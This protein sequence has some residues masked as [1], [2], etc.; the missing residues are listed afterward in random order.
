MAYYK[1]QTP[2]RKGEDYVYPL[3]T[4]DQ[5]I[6]ENGERLNAKY[7][8]VELDDTESGVVPKTNANQLGGIDAEAYATKAFVS[9]E[10]ANAQLGGGEGADIDLSGFMLKTDT[11]VDSEKLGGI[12]AENYALKSDLEDL[13]LDPVIATDENN[14]GNIVLENYVS[15]SYAEHIGDLGNPHNVTIAQIG[16]A[17]AG[18]G[19]GG[20]AVWLSDGTDIDSVVQ[21][22]WYSYGANNI[23]TN[24]PYTIGNIF[25]LARGTS[26]TC[27]QLATSR[28][29]AAVYMK[30]RVMYDNG[31]WS[32][33][34]EFSPS[35]FAPAG[36]GL[37]TNK[38]TYVT[39]L[40]EA[41]NAGWY[42]NSS[43]ALN[44]PEQINYGAM[45]VLPRNSTDFTQILT[46]VS[47]GI[48]AYR[49]STNNGFREWKYLNGRQAR[50]VTVNSSFVNSGSITA[51]TSGNILKIG[52]YL[53][54]KIQQAGDGYTTNIICTI[55]G[56]KVNGN[57]YATVVDHSTGKPYNILLFYNGTNTVVQLECASY[58]LP[59]YKWLNFGIV[60]IIE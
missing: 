1:L 17:P 57:T 58:A 34:E 47:S 42:C 60:G 25:V 27:T 35:A 38:G 9:A 33:W 56:V 24:K 18:Y 13:D 29:N 48:I 39:D 36:F 8:S 11:A 3:T 51:E 2:L 31:I 15:D 6:V 30:V 49:T 21:C 59:A 26:G 5:V 37:G 50:T 28:N 45:L 40:N 46:D 52:G 23:S 20:D 4:A 44:C 54:T 32:T 55:P 43:G 14:D 53:E 41:K 7:V 16:A 12:E 10:I 19:L 22:G